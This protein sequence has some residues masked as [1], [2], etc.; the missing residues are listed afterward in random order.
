MKKKIKSR[1]LIRRN[2]VETR[3]RILRESTKL[4]AVT[5]YAGTSISMLIDA[6]KVNQ[7]MIYHY[8]SDKEGLY[9]EVFLN[10]WGELKAWFD[11][12]LTEEVVPPEE[13]D[14]PGTYLV[15]RA[16]EIFFDFMMTHHDF[17][18]LMM[19]EGLEG[20]TVS[21]SIWKDVRGPLF[22]QVT[23]LAK[24]AQKEGRLSAT[25]DPA[26]LIVSFLGVTTFYF[27]YASSIG[28]MIGH[29]PFEDVAIKERKRHVKELLLQLMRR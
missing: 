15:T 24:L 25:I 28:D 22:E 16:L 21:R 12:A 10:Q 29:E 7:R 20:G 8:F 23:S 9:R 5:G 4:F 2:P 18:R 26:Q 14:H 17:V 19:W 3:A 1:P 13:A 6:A 11:Q 27:A